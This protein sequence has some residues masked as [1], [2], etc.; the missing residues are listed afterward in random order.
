M[1][2]GARERDELVSV[3]PASGKE[4]PSAV[5][6]ATIAAFIQAEERESQGMAE[7]VVQAVHSGGLAV[8]EAAACVRAL[9]RGQVDTL[10]LHAGY[11][12]EPGWVC[13]ACGLIA[14]EQR[15]PPACPEC[16]G[17]RSGSATPG[18]KWCASPSNCPP[19][20]RSSMKA[21]PWRSSAASAAC[22]AIGS[23]GGKAHKH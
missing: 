13:A 11:A 23:R 15:K 10:V 16:G 12:P 5:V 21:R 9:Q 4:A 6:E 18:R 7:L 17:A 1:P 14:L 19:R 8:A 3:V 22:C 20:R 2:P